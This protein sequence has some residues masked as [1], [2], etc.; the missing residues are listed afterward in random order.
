M[1]LENKKL[2]SELKNMENMQK[3][4]QELMNEKNMAAKK[5]ENSENQAKLIEKLNS[6]LTIVEQENRLLKDQMNI[7]KLTE[8]KT[9]VILS[10]KTVE[11]NEIKKDI[12]LIKELT[13]R[14][15]T[16]LQLFN[17]MFSSKNSFTSSKY[18]F[19]LVLLILMILK[20]KLQ[21]HPSKVCPILYLSKDTGP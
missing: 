20:H 8:E 3:M 12:N 6:Q 14:E 2:K 13:N 17:Q 16:E 4:S 9:N 19:C 21:P 18:H 1:Q 5:Y 15:K 11:L 7:M 10:A